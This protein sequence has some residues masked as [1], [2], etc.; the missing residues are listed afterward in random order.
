MWKNIG[1]VFLS[2]IAVILVVVV[3]AVASGEGTIWWNNIFG[4]GISSSQTEVFQ[5]SKAYTQ[6]M[7]QDLARQMEELNQSKDPEA[8][9]AIISYIQE[10]YAS[11]DPNTINN[12]QLRS[13]LIDVMNGNIK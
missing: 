6:G 5:H 8:R 11:Y 3:I 10:T 4:A 1:Y 12:P 2:I 7:A 13:F 9:G